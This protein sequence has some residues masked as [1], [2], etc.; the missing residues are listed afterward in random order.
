MNRVKFVWLIFAVAFALRVLVIF[1]AGNFQNPRTYEHGAIAHN[2][3]TGHG[4]AMH[5]PY[6]PLD[7][8]RIRIM[9][10]PPVFESSYQPPLN[11]YIMY[12]A[13]LLLGEGPKAYLALMLF[14]AACNSLIGV[15]Q[16]Y[17]VKEFA[18][19]SLSRSTAIVSA[20][21]I[22]AAFSVTT[23]S[24]SPLYIVVVATLMLFAL[25][26]SRDPSWKNFIL[27]GFISG[28]SMLLRSELFA[29]GFTIL[30]ASAML[31]LQ[32]AS[33][34]DIFKRAVVA[35]VCSL[36]I[37]GPWTIRNYELFHKFV[38]TVDRP[39]HEIWRGNN[40]LSTPSG[41]NSDGTVVWLKPWLFPKLVH[42]ADSIP[43]DQYFVIRLDSVFRHEAIT[44]VRSHPS[45]TLALGCRKLLMLLTFSINFNER[46]THAFDFIYPFSMLALTFPTLIG[47]AYLLRRRSN[48][49]LWNAG[50]L[51]T[52][53]LIF[54]CGIS[55]I[56]FVIPRY[57]IYIFAV[58]TPI[59]II[60]YDSIWTLIKK[61]TVFALHP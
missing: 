47:I 19:E 61:R 16:Y 37:I 20:F 21:F 44:Y 34:N 13:Y 5:W 40:A 33:R 53:F 43:Y 6:E 59:A 23:F 12:G 54:Y 2:L 41:V 35:A 14:Y 45:Q 51:Y 46:S 57:Q 3:L 52:L 28:V 10:S 9:Q 22:P 58:L 31:A 42:T 8:A 25:R 60:G 29:L 38:P 15:I 48:P 27:F 18:G 32:R 1:V 55:F 17:A 49:R 39:W 7:S 11:P 26:I 36:I 30:A 56:T 24:G 4:Y 50:I